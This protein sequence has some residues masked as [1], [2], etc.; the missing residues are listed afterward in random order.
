MG[1]EHD[2]NTCI[3]GVLYLDSGRYACEITFD[4]GIVPACGC[5]FIGE[6]FEAAPVL[7]PRPTFR[8]WMCAMYH[9][10]G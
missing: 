3:H 8:Q 6:K 10:K 7:Y 2:G 1:K 4:E 5:P 9:K